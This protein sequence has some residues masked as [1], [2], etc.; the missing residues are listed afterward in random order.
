MSAV[1]FRVDEKLKA[2]AVEKLSVQGISLSDALRDTLTYIA[3]TG[4]SPVK[5]TLVT[6][7]DAQ[8]I[9][10]VRERLKNRARK[11]RITFAELKSRHH[12]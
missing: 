6:D 11:H 1:T 3:E 9:E 4:R 10:I 5:R 2:A 8:L 12:E 7:E